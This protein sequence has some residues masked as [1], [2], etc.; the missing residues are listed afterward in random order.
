VRQS[1]RLDWILHTWPFKPNQV[2]TIIVGAV[3]FALFLALIV[4]AL[5]RGG[6]D[7]RYIP[8]LVLVTVVS[9]NTLVR[10]IFFPR[11]SPSP[12]GVGGQLR[13]VNGLLAVIGAILLQREWRKQRIRRR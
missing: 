3:G 1:Q 2:A 10:G 12:A 13:L 6:E 9:L 8:G 5:R 11:L 7:R 4:L